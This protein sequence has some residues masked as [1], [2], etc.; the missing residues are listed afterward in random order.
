MAHDELFVPRLD[1]FA[2]RVAELKAKIT[3]SDAAMSLETTLAELDTAM[4][5]LRVA[6]E[7]LRQKTGE[8]VVARA[9][10]QM[11]VRH[12]QSLFEFAPDAYL[13]TDLKGG[14]RE[15]NQVA[16]PLLNLDRSALRGMPL[17]TLVAPQDRPA[18]RQ[19]LAELAR[20][21]GLQEWEAQLKPREG[22]PFPASLRAGVETDSSGKPVS[23]YWLIRDITQSRGVFQQ[24]EERY[25]LLVEG[26]RDYAIFQ[27][28][29]GGRVAT[30]NSGAERI[31]GYTEAEILGR[32]GA[33]FFVLED[34]ERGEDIKEMETARR[35]GRA[36]D[37]RWHLR[38]NGSR[39]WGSGVMTALR[40]E[41]GTLLGFVKVMQDK[42]D[43]WLAD[44]A[45][46]QSEEKLRLVLDAAQMGHWEW[47]IQTGRTV[48]S[49]EYN[50]ILGL[51]DG[52]DREGDWEQ[53]LERVSAEDRPAVETAVRA[54]IASGEDWESEFRVVL[55]NKQRR[56]V[57]IRGHTYY[58]DQGRAER[59]LGII[60][61]VTERKHAEEERLKNLARIAEREQQT[62]ILQERN[63]MAQDIH[64]TLAQGFTGI[65]IQL[66]AAEDAFEDSSGALLDHINRARE[67]ARTSLTEA[68]RSIEA[69]RPSVLDKHNLPEALRHL[70]E[71]TTAGTEAKVVLHVE[72]EP[73]VLSEPVEEHLLRIGQEGLANAL[74]H[75]QASRITLTVSFQ[76]NQV[77]VRVS[78]NGV[79]FSPPPSL[80]AM[81][82]QTGKG[83]GLTGIQERAR[84]LGGQVT[85]QSRPD[86]GTHIEVSVPVAVSENPATENG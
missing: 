36:A 15:A 78:D 68:R 33:L 61:D 18:F 50:R 81:S 44:Q 65:F 70:I 58:D 35:E 64:D 1:K 26:L 56:W 13:V 20:N 57:A 6:E 63:R 51:P 8:L 52:S 40:D 27:L 24:S 22:K 34:R 9:A 7:E 60:H 42:T 86:K 4:E 10:E 85:I 84:L 53:C 41:N 47:D 23:L 30:W 71:E 5:E 28:D 76:P 32:S 83:L 25:R 29:I 46:R 54:S 67:L 39:F 74:K 66:E 43:A 75:S 17:L 73:F 72:G 49:H 82:A 12:Y 3:D 79:G 55:P 31:L 16:H 77:Q 45:L 69:L 11:Q 21:P 14:I 19:R 48:W 37:E 38:K 2:H 59:M 62:A 80:A